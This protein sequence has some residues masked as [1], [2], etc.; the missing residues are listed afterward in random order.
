MKPLRAHFNG[1]QPG[2]GMFPA[3]ELWTLVTDLGRYP[4]GSTV[5]RQTIEK[6]GYVPQEIKINLVKHTLKTHWGIEERR[7]RYE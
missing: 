7:L 5:S 4:K 3:F 6:A 2:W 1:I